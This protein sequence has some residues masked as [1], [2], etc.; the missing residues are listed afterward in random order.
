VS[1]SQITL[2]RLA[3]DDEL[4]DLLDRVLESVAEG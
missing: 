2:R 3:A 4:G 1:H